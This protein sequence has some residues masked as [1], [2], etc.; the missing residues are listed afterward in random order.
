M[1]RKTI[2]TFATAAVIAGAVLSPTV[3]SADWYGNNRRV[4]TRSDQR[5]I[6]TDMLDIQRDRSDLSRDQRELARDLR[7]GRWTDVARDLADIRRDRMRLREDQQ[8]LR[9]D[10]GYQ[11][12]YRRGY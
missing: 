11:Y 1:T 4:D 6:R 7:S 3:A 12:I 2:V 9:R 10:L 8:D 5:D